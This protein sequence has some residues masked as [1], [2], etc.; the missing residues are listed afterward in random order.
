MRTWVE[1]PITPESIV[2]LA[3][4][5][6]DLLR[7]PPTVEV[8]HSALHAVS[9]LE[10]RGVVPQRVYGNAAGGVWIEFDREIVL[11]IR[12]DGSVD[13]GCIVTRRRRSLRD[14]IGDVSRRLRRRKRATK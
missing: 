3:C 9:V 14:A 5:P 10:A 12:A 6:S 4:G 7:T 1:A 11:G 8:M 2:S 13:S